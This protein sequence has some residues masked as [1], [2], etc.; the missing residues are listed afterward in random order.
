MSTALEP[1][2]ITIH[3]DGLTLRPV[4]PADA[5]Q[6]HLHASDKRVAENTTTIPHPLPKG[7]TEAFINRS[8]APERLEDVWRLLDC[9]C[10]VEL[11]ACLS[12]C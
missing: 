12:H 10:T 2:Q 6:I 5:G 8:L 3:G 11:R 4:T 9:A 1:Q 7:V